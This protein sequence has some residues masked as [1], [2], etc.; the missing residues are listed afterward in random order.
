MKAAIEAAV[1]QHPALRMAAR[2]ADRLLRRMRYR[3]KTHGVKTDKKLVLFAAYAGHSYACSPKAL[4]EEMLRDEKYRDHRFVWLFKEPESYRFL[5]ANGRTT[6]LRFGSVEAERAVRR[7]KYWVINFT[8]PESW[9]PQKDQ[10]Y[11]QCW[12]GTPLKKLG[13]DITSSENAMNSPAEIHMRY[14]HDAARF[15]YLLAPS[16]FAA[17]KFR[18]VWAIDRCNKNPASCMIECGYPRNDFLKRFTPEDV[19]RV[20]K[21]LG[22]ENTGKKL[23]LYAPTWRDDQYDPKTGYTYKSPVDFDALQRA[24]GK[25]YILL[26]RT[27]YLAA[28]QTDFEK[29]KGFLLDVSDVD[30]VNDLYIVS[31]MLI[32]DYS[33]VFFDY[34]NLR[35]P[36]LFYMYDLAHYRG[37]LHDFYLEPE[38]L[39]G[40]IVHTEQAL[41]KAV[42]AA[43]QNGPSDKLEA[44]CARFTPLDDGNAAK[45][46]LE[47][48][49]S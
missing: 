48:L 17:E 2:K 33:S 16:A 7:A 21:Q 49:F 25:D 42:K 38:E 19:Q 27:H 30:D 24:L 8:A 20:K 11:L 36:I 10:V 39:P 4:F 32:T 14:R 29:Y 34:A 31:D 15:T 12:H 40:E 23:I 22:L 41:I 9:V 3:L 5:E 18:S 44:F 26:F 6:V 13:F 35:R 46:V 28:Q 43:A 45:R 1:K 37:A 47:V